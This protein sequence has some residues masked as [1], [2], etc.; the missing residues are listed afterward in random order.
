M[1]DHTFLA[2]SGNEPLREHLELVANRA[3]SYAK[4][5]D[6][7][8]EAFLAGLIHDIGKYSNLFLRR[9]E[10]KEKGLDH[11]SPGAS[12]ALIKYKWNAFAAALAIQGHHIGLQHG[13]PGSLKKELSLEYLA[14]NHPL[15]LRL[16]EK[17]PNLLL[18][19]FNADGFT[20]P[21]EPESSL[22]DRFSTPVAGMLDIR[23]LYSCLVDADFIETEAHF[24]RDAAGNR[25]Y[26]KPGLELQPEKALKI[27]LENMYKIRQDSKAE[28]TVNSIRDD[29]FKTCLEAGT[30]SPGIFT[31]TAPTG[32]GKTLSMLAFALK[33]ACTHKN[34][35]KRII[36]VIPYLTIIEQT[37]NIY[38]EMFSP[39]F[40]SQ[41]VLE[42]HS[43][44]GT[45][46]K[47]SQDEL[48]NDEQRKLLSEN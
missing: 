30:Q 24:Q 46:E 1:S 25:S 10:N 7:E 37:A 17:D 6:A 43:L 38:R 32:A 26:R 19:R 4:L 48:E 33:H 2:H 12:I 18:E 22:Y 27:L 34:H 3:A 15:N 29:L 11:W 36:F 35:F 47:N 44:A 16:T 28:T 13:F 8:K 42:H 39:L 21:Q 41:Y 31:L 9:L 45:R 23:M 14:N 40:G 20:F 5:F